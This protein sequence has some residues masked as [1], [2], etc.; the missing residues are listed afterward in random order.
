MEVRSQLEALP[1]ERAL[2][3]HWIE[4]WV[5]LRAQKEKS[6]PLLEIKPQSSIPWL[7]FTTLTELPQLLEH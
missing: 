6:S 3:N 1:Q 7:H 5:K 4:Q 2:G